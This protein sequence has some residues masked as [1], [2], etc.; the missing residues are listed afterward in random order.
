MLTYLG[1]ALVGTAVLGIAFKSVEFVRCIHL[2]YV[3]KM[4]MGGR[5]KRKVR[6]PGT[7]QEDDLNQAKKRQQ[8]DKRN[9][10]R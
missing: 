8:R 9:K 7:T 10:K 5:A 3:R 4:E 6:G 1:I 2:V